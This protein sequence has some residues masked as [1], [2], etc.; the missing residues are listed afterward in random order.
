MKRFFEKKQDDIT[1]GDSLVFVMLYM[2]VYLAIMG[3]ILKL[4]DV[5]DCVKLTCLR[6]KRLLYKL[7]KKIVG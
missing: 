7:K 1:I 6:I 3:I 2:M 4:D 5:V